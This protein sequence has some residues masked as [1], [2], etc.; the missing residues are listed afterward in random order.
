ML[1]FYFL[2]IVLNSIAGYL[3]IAK[4]DDEG[5][6]FKSGF[7][8]KDETF[9]LVVAALSAITGLFKILSAIEGDVRVIGDLVPALAGFL[10]G[11]VLFFEHSRNNLSQDEPEYQ[12]KVGLILISNKRAIGITAVIAAALHFFFPSVL[13]L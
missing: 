4:D 7:S 8:I 12:G 6:E 3:L 9:R 11:L 1:Q 13:L 10:A 5:L 2:S